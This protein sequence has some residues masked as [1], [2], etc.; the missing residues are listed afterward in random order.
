MKK[1]ILFVLVLFVVGY[2]SKLHAQNLSV[3]GAFRSVGTNSTIT[4]ETVDTTYFKA[5]IPSSGDL[6]LFL[7][8]TGESGNTLTGVSKLWV[9]PDSLIWTLYPLP[10][11]IDSITKTYNA[12]ALTATPTYLPT[13]TRQ[14]TYTKIYTFPYF[15]TTSGT[16]N[17]TN[18]NPFKW[19][20]WEFI[21][22]AATSGTVTL[23]GRYQCRKVG[24]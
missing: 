23:S 6:T 22:T 15:L 24:Q 1:V 9:S 18:G 11:S 17:I 13:S 14:Y 12:V 21:S 19:Y 10:N 16:T 8:F 5:S 4:T 20:M 3:E 7:N 2:N